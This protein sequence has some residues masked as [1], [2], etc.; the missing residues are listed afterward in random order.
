[1][2]KK[3]PFPRATTVT[4]WLLLVPALLLAVMFKFIPLAE[5]IYYSFHKVTPYLG[6]TWVGLDNYAKVLTSSGFTAA[7]GHTVILACVQTAGSVI[8]G[9]LLALVLEGSGIGLWLTRTVVVLPVV[10]ATAVIGEIWRIIYFPDAGGFLNTILGWFH[11]GPSTFLDSPSTALMSVAAVGIWSGAPYNMVIFLA[12][13]AGIDRNL[14][15]AA[16][17]DGAGRWRRLWSI[18]IPSLRSSM[19]IVLTLAAIRALGIF[20]EVYVLTGGG[21]A[22]STTTW[23]TQVYTQGF[24]RSDVGVASAASMLLLATTLTLTIIVR[25]LAARRRES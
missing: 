7:L 1:M 13:L 16:A 6:N 17:V 19:I 10:T 18:V 3:L 25:W 5:G 23:M 21:P 9:L 8:G 14:Y 15:E 22:N 20:T 11:L 24:D 12:G 4:M 2:R